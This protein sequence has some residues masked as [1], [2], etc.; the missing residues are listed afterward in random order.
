M[1][2]DINSL[3]SKVNDEE[4]TNLFLLKINIIRVNFSHMK[5]KISKNL[6]TFFKKYSNKKLFYLYYKFLFVII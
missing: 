5:L 6:Y 4:L 3:I 2:I 1:K